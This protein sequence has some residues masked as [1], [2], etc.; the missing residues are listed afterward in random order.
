MC[1]HPAGST[2][3]SGI[4]S[5][6]CRSE[7]RP[8]SRSSSASVRAAPSDVLIARQSAPRSAGSVKSC[9]PAFPGAGIL[10]GLSSR[11]RSVGR[12]IIG[13]MAVR[14]GSERLFDSGALRGRRV[15]VV[16]NPASVDS[17]YRHILDRI[18]S[19]PGVTLA[20]IFGPQ[21]GFRSDVQDNMIETG[22]AKDATTLRAHL[23]ALQ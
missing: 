7:S 20:A 10:P 22:H 3:A 14:L 2:V 23:L 17:G 18:R 12:H 15:G 16:C 6:P 13:R 1:G 11:V 19:E 5:V 8:L 4:T 9:L 21:H